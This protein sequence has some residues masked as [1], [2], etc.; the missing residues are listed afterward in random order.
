MKKEGF[1]YEI[2][3]FLF[4]LAISFICVFVFTHWIAKPVKVDGSSMYP[5]LKDHDIAFSGLWNTDK[6][7]RFDIVVIRLEDKDK[8][9]VKRVIGL[10]NETVAV[11]DDVLY[12]NGEPIEQPFLDEEYVTSQRIN[13]IFTYDIEEIQL[14]DDEYYVLGDNRINSQDSRYYGPFHQSQIVSKDFLII[15]PFNRIGLK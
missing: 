12:I 9:I 8:Y 3:S 7:E 5:T 13:G 14:N 4:T 6:I 1:L 11:Y 15:Y 10:P 2:V